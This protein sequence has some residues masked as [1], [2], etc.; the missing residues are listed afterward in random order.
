MSYDIGLKMTLDTG[1]D[2]PFVVDLGSWNYTFN[3]S[4]M[5]E[6]A[7]VRETVLKSEGK[8]AAECIPILWEG[9][10]RM[11]AEPV[12]YLAMNPPNEWGDYSGAMQFLRNIYFGCKKHPKATV[13]TSY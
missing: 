2:E 5:F 3:C 6:A 9:I 13:W 7:G 1:G 12:K 11:E 4:E 8:T 10:R